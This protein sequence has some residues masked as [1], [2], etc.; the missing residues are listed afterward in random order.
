[1]CAFSE[2]NIKS[3]WEL[4]YKCGYGKVNKQHIPLLNNAF[5][6]EALSKY[7]ILCVENL[8]HEIA[9]A[10]P[11]F[12]QVANFLWPLKLSNPS[13]G[14]RMRKFKHFV[15]SGDFGDRETNTWLREKFLCDTS[16]PGIT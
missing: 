3:V 16:R 6:E 13:G 4:I 14:W 5:I 1:M 10:G 12:K 9:T 11:N 8:V 7:N 15:Q 2:P